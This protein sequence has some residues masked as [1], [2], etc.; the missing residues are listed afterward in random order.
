MKFT[1]IF[2]VFRQ[3]LITFKVKYN[4]QHHTPQKHTVILTE[5]RALICWVT[6]VVVVGVTTFTVVTRDALCSA[7]TLPSIR[8]AL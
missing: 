6:M 2:G 1:C 4:L 8:V 3:I 5:T 7:V